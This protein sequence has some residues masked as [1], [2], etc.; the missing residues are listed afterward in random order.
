M[1]A[2]HRKIGRNH[3]A[4]IWH[5]VCCW[6]QGKMRSPE[7]PEWVDLSDKGERGQ[8][9]TRAWGQGEESGFDS[10]VSWIEAVSRAKLGVSRGKT[11]SDLWT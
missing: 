7:V 3:Q 5:H 1:I 4:K 10:G 11:E 8:G 9:Q 2:T 6:R